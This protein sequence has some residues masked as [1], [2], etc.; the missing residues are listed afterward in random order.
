MKRKKKINHFNIKR[1]FFKLVLLSIFCL[2]PLVGSTNAV[3]LDTES[4]NN[5]LFSA[6][7][8]DFSL[9]SLSGFTPLPLA[10]GVSASRSA[11]VSNEGSLGFNYDIRSVKTGG[12]DDFC[13]ALNLEVKF[14]G[15]TKYNSSLLGFVLSPAVLFGGSN[16]WEFIVH[17]DSTDPS[18][19]NKTCDFNFVFKGWQIDSDGSWGMT[20]EEILANTV[21][22]GDWTAPVISNIQHL[23]ATPNESNEPKAVVTWETDE[24][25]TSNLKWRIDSGPWNF[26]SEDTTADQIIHS[27]EISGLLPSTV[28]KFRVISKDS[29]GNENI[30]GPNLLETD[31]ARGGLGGIGKIVINE[32]LPNPTGDDNALMPG[33]EWVEIYNRGSNLRD[34]SGWYL[35]DFGGH[36]LEITTSNT[37]SSNNTTSGL[38]IA[39][40]EFLVVYRHGDSDFDLNNGPLGDMVNLYTSS[41]WL[42]D[43]H[44]YTVVFGDEVLEN[45][46]FARFPDGSNFWFDP[47]PTPG[48]PNVLETLLLTPSIDLDLS[49]DKK[50]VSFKV[51]NIKEFKKLSYEL[52]YETAIKT[53]GILGEKE[54]DNQDEFVK[55]NIILG[56]CSSGGTCVY[57]LGI[58]EIKLKVILV[59]Q[60]NGEEILEKSLNYD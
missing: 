5:N 13:N 37:V 3:Y 39:P 6:G 51:K 52:A 46:S 2:V 45:K 49:A 1:S 26:L 4:S 24:L 14:D 33:G 29:S 43:Y 48:E 22:S 7:S 55:E 16:S 30:S 38:I 10:P 44:A 19:Q 8:L 47:V 31:G 27:R 28:Y 56:T 53:E 34:L 23:I 59:N 50:T 21:N 15:L 54:L 40:Q 57:H 11:L 41:G 17:F 25:A 9:T 35:T 36:H 42:V 20:D 60:E 18:L 12:N 32:F 58:K